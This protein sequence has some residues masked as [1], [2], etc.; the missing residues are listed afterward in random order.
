MGTLAFAFKSK[1]EEKNNYKLHN[2]I[3]NDRIKTYLY[4][5][6]IQK[7]VEY[8]SCFT[9]LTVKTPHPIIKATVSIDPNTKKIKVNPSKATT[10][11]MLL[12]P[13]ELLER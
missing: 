12:K 2:F 7:W 10:K 5:E 4:I 13:L 9:T 6:N 1:N 8:I 3:Y 11:R